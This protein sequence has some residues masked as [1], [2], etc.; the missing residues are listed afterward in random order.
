MFPRL[1]YR[2]FLTFHKIKDRVEQ[3]ITPSGRLAL[4]ALVFS[5]VMGLDTNQSMAFQV[6]SWLLMVMIVSLA[7][8]LTWRLPTSASR[9]LPRFG[10]AGELLTY[11]ILISHSS[12]QG[13]PPAM[14]YDYP[15]TPWPTYEEFLRAPDPKQEPSNPVD[16]RLGYY[17]WLGLLHRKRP[18]VIKAVTTPPWSPGTPTEVRIE[19]RPL[20]RG[21]LQLSKLTL[22]RPDP[23]G[24]WRS[25]RTLGP[26]DSILILP[27]RYPVRAIAL[28]GQRKYQP[29]GVAM[30]YSVGDSEEFVSLRDYRPGDPLRRIHWKSWAKTEKP[31]V[32]EYLDEFFV[33]HALILDTFQ[34]DETEEVFEEAV[35]AAASLASNILT[36]DSLL[37]LMF[38][39]PQAYCFTSGRGIAQVDRLMEILAVVQPCRDKPFG[40]LEPLVL[41]RAGW[42][43]ACLCVFLNWNQD[44]QRLVGRL[45]ALGMPIKVLVV[46]GQ[47]T[48]TT[49]GPGIMAGDPTNFHVLAAGQM[50]E[51]L[52]RI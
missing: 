29:G 10:T 44:R 27:K 16:R 48:E 38:V 32:K 50:A 26:V 4:I 18:A 14:L 24:L 2:S 42:L 9:I 31:V 28:P 39:G 15:E 7:T 3:R 23:L 30:A 8:S 20:R 37:D 43:S 22:A 41:Q 1:R 46:A 51:G 33:R 13:Q 36:Q 40:T 47:G 6:F 12:P 45:Q 17:R 25:V 21:R 34:N 5:A 11:R 35:S 52:S 49:L 19:A